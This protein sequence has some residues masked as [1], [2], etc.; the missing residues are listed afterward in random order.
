MIELETEGLTKIE[1]M[2]DLSRRITTGSS[3]TDEYIQNISDTTYGKVL[4]TTYKGQM[5]GLYLCDNRLLA[6]QVMDKDTNR[7]GAVYI[8]KIKNIV[9]NIDACFVE[10]ANGE[11]CFLAGKDA[12]N[13]ILL[14]RKYDGRLLEGDELLIQLTREAQKTKQ[15][16][17]TA[18]LS[19]SNEYAVISI[20]S[21]RVG[22]SGKL[23]KSKKEEIRNWLI[24]NKL[25]Q[26]TDFIYED[27]NENINK[28][29]E[30]MKLSLGLVL[31]TK[32]GT[33]TEETLLGKLREL[34]NDFHSMVQKAQHR[35]CFSCIRSAPEEF[36]AILDRM[37][38]PHEYNEILTDDS[39]LYDKLCSYCTE[40][41]PDKTVRL[42][43]DENFSLS[44][45]Y[46]LKAKMETALNTRIWL[47]SGGYLV[48]E[49]TEALTV[50]D[51]NTGKYEVSR[52]SSDT[53]EIIN[54]EAA[55]EVALQL[56]LRNLSGIIIVDFINMKSKEAE[57][58]L[59]HYLQDLVRKDKVKT[60]VV[61]ITPLGLVEITRKKQNKTLREQFI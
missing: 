61:D 54:M 42:Y 29:T 40:Y 11:L 47:K 39:L 60:S 35:T 37:V 25:L 28:D 41:L 26:E 22:Y 6:A 3:H 59:L 14:N 4:F 15:A 48:I 16:S 7:I 30:D 56:R 38:Y 12:S 1:G 20:G 46:S 45:L 31:R 43:Q 55:R 53:F 57:E 13:P 49:H 51:V 19:L 33:C 5:C 17:V 32:A 44:K 58:A 23:D 27:V 18:N 10:I 50:I 24:K 52:S 9:K 2:T 34:M 21:K 8:G 36:E